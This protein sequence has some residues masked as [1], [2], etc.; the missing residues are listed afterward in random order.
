MTNAFYLDTCIWR[1]FSEDRKSKSGRAL[2]KEAARLIHR[3]IKDKD[4]IL[5]SDLIIREISIAYAEAEIEEQLRFLTFTGV[6]REV[7]ITEEQIIEAKGIAAE[8]SLPVADALHAIIARDNGATFITQDRH[9]DRLRDIVD[10]R[11]PDET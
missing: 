9:G 10:V 8:R 2:G 4:T 11:K 6:L 7:K 5:F 1:D 3:I